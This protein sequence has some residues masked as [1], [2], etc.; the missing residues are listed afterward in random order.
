MHSQTV[1]VPESLQI[2]N[3]SPCAVH[4]YNCETKITVLLGWYTSKLNIKTGH[5]SVASITNNNTSVLVK[6]DIIKARI[7][8]D[9]KSKD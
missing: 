7:I 3:K 4:R 1:L 2:L 9:S 8:N 5:C 6:Q